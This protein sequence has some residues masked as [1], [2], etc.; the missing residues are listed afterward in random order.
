[1]INTITAKDIR[2]AFVDLIHNKAQIPYDVHFNHVNKST[3]SYVWVELQMRKSS[4][5]IAF[6]QW[7]IDVD[8]QVILSPDDYAV[9]KYTGLWEIADSLTKSI[10]PCMQIK[11]RFIT[12]QEFNSNVVDDVLHYEFNLDFTDYV[13]S[14]EYE[15]VGYELMQE[16]NLDLES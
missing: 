12:I 7:S 1:M 3:T 6:F 8:I 4:W 11:D 14:D 2:A 9:V 16:L 5:D 13:Q 10:M 15:G